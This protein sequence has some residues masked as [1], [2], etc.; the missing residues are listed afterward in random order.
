MVL[1]FRAMGC[2]R[3]LHCKLAVDGHPIRDF[4]AAAREMDSDVLAPEAEAEIG[5]QASSER[6]YTSTRSRMRSPAVPQWLLCQRVEPYA[7]PAVFIRPSDRDIQ[8]W[9]IWTTEQRH[10]AEPDIARRAASFDIVVQNVGGLRPGL[11][12]GHRKQLPRGS[13]GSE[14]SQ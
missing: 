8:R 4:R 6:S 12:P 5:R 3:N 2:G 7:F 14:I 9:V 1:N 13:I 10:Q 11:A